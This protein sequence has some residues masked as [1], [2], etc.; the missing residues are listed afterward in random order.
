MKNREVS[1]IFRQI[2]EILEVKGENPFR[3]R[4]YE[5]AA[6]VIESLS[7]EVEVLTKEKN[8]RKIEGIGKDLEE[9]IKEIIRSGRLK[10]LDDLKKDVPTG[11]LEMLRVPGVGPG[12]A[13]IL[14]EKLNVNNIVMLE[15]VAHAGKI[16]GLPGM[17]K[18]TEDNI[19]RG[20]ELVKRGRESM[21]IRTAMDI[22]AYF[23]KEIRRGKEVIRVDAAGSLR[24]MKGSIRDIDIVVCS[25]KPEKTL[26]RFIS[27][28]EVKDVLGKGISKSSIVTKDGIQADMRF[29]DKDS[30]GAGLM[31]FTGS[32]EHNVKLRHIAL[33]NGL[34]LNEYGIF[35]KNRR[36]AGKT[37]TE[38]YKALDLPFITP[39]LREDRGEI[40]A[41]FKK[42]LPDLIKRSDIKG[43]LHV[44]SA[45][46]DGGDSIEEMVI[47]A[48]QLGYEYI[49]ITDHSQGLKVANGLDAGKLK[50]KRREIEALRK[51]HKDIKILYG[52]EVDINANGSLDYADSVLK[53]MDIVVG[54]LHSGFKQKRDAITK[55]LLK[56]CSNKYVH[57]IAHPTGMLRGARDPYEVDLEEIFRAAADTD[58]AIEINSF[59]QRLDLNDINCRLAKQY[60][61][62]IAINTDAHLAAQLDFMELGVSTARRGWLEKG[63]VLNSVSFGELRLK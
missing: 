5:K 50:K 52:A 31:Y 47:K 16:K 44:H 36:I 28:A 2:A 56:A 1:D 37:E 60:G 17:K 19:I 11:F 63:D 34:K 48:K 51:V 35:R 26:E 38:M 40:E 46:S 20:L 6:R 55:R 24:R 18:K 49:A 23:L 43:D 41:G 12:K 45:Y 33:S 42:K 7:E 39:E 32:K 54:A 27:L 8:L 14:R 21:D 25:Q 53:E 10:Y 3:I 15:R 61:V 4:A 57:I 30:Y 9:K 13:R 22:A 29:M 62:K 58:T 59:P